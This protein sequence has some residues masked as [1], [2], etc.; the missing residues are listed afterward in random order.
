[1][2]TQAAWLVA[3]IVTSA[4]S[5]AADPGEGALHDPATRHN[6]EAFPAAG[7][8]SLDDLHGHGQAVPGPI[9]QHTHV[10][11]VGPGVAHSAPGS[12][13][14]QRHGRV[15]VLDVG[16]GDHH[17]DK[18][19]QHIGGDVPLTAL[20]AFVR[21]EAAGGSVDDTFGAGVYG[22][23]VDRGGGGQTPAAGSH[24]RSGP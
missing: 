10:A 17:G 11:A 16:C 12:L 14:Q 18:E 5:P 24:A 8:D 7:I 15:S 9:N 19:T 13:G 6:V 21:V 22:L 2:C 1:M 23:S 4:P 20:H 3:F